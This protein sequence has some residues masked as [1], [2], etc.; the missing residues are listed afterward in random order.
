MTKMK[1]YNSIGEHVYTAVTENGLRVTVV[2]KRGFNKAMAFFATNY[3][4][5]DRRFQCKGQWIDTPAGVAHFLE[6]KMFDMEGGENALTLLSERGA[7][8]NAFTSAGMTA[9]HFESTEHFEDNLRLLLQFVSKPYFTQ[10]SVDKEQGIIGQEIRMTEDDPN[11]AI[12]HDFMK[13]LY[14]ENPIRDSVAG[15][16]ESI[17][18]IT[19]QTLY[20]CHEVFY[21]PS[22]MSLCVVGDV[23]PQDIMKIVNEIL[24]MPAG[25]RPARDY[26]EEKSQIPTAA[27]SDRVMDVGTPMFL[28]GSK[29]SPSPAGTAY[30]KQELTGEL[31]LSILAGRSSPLYE[32]LYNDGLIGKDFSVEFDQVAGTATILF[33]GQSK[34]PEAVFEA[35]QSEVQRISKDGIDPA[36]FDRRKK[37]M[38]G[39]KIRALNSFDNICYTVSVGNF[40]GFDPFATTDLLSKLSARDIEAFLCENV[41]REKM[42]MAV[43]HAN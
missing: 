21:N 4:G 9:Y 13:L 19:A 11:Y 18:E 6:H 26:G 27:R 29:A 10:E 22:N 36:L 7:S 1:F 40:N 2:S 37:A 25:E 30:L 23:D 28:I 35:I 3:G 15:T 41:T 42:A 43:V 32:R 14:A 39:R 12:Y 34:D 16:V 33:E 38:L 8:A 24:T 17:R 20:D 31:A 5:A